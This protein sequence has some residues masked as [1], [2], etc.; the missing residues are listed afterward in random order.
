MRPRLSLRAAAL[1]VSLLAA[2]GLPDS[3]AALPRSGESWIQLRTPHFTFF[4]NGSE[5]ATRNI[6]LDLE[7]LRSSLS[8]LN[9][10]LALA[11][12][13]PTS[14]YVFK[15]TSSFAPYRL[16]YEGRLQSGEGYFVSHPYGNHVAINA[17][18]RGDAT[19]VIYHE[20]LHDVLNHNYPGLPLWLNEGLAEF[21][22]TFE[23]VGGEAK[24]GLPI[25]RHVF[26]LRDN[27]MIPLR[28]LLA[29][30]T[31]SR[32]YNEGSRRGVF[33]AQSWALVH[34]LLTG[35][36]ERR[37]Q[38]GKYLQAMLDGAGSAEAFERSF[39]DLAL[40]ERDL[41]S[42]VR[43]AAFNYL[44]VPVAEEASVKVEVAPLAGAD[45]L[46]RLGDLLLH[47]GD[48]KHTA[49]EEHFRAALAAA[50]GHGP[51]TAG[52]GRIAASASRVAEARAHYARAAQLAPDDYFIHYLL[53]V[54]LLEPAPEPG[55][56]PQARAA[57]QKSVE[58]RP[59]FAEGWGRWAQALSYEN[60]LPPDSVMVFE[61]AYH[62]M[63]AREDFAFN[64]ALVY[65][66]TGQRDKAEK[67]IDQALVPRNRPEIVKQARQAV[68]LG[69]W[70]EI[71]KTLVEPGK[72]AEALPRLEALLPR[73]EDPQRGLTLRKRLDEI[74]D[75]ADY[76]SFSERYNRA[77]D[78][79][80][81]GKDADALKLLEDLA[82]NTRNA[83][84]AEEARSLLDR[85][86]K[87]P[88]RK[89]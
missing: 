88:K 89:P 6:A 40:L 41:R 67:L 63:P 58:L 66:R 3:A 84:Q 8:Q 80:N 16:V 70:E 17:D 73:L 86:K 54:S 36:P 12:P 9:P 45:T 28:E 65:A 43:S 48:E 19:R 82:A 71:E 10:G 39:G 78:L 24:V 68:L 31:S 59:D 2:S 23:V 32:D 27:A 33:Y 29:M 53:G 18:P 37:R 38:T 83:G 14:I 51:A 72:L 55:A 11:S 56:L 30:N 22:S 61:T 49:A 15:G 57:L 76:N 26:W 87:A 75:V 13:V 52:L 46:Y 47:N 7:R 64:L 34:H 42:Y 79:L 4:S 1:A 85:A 69:E 21:Y 50:P 35:S 74:R 62:L 20:Y 25:S 60:P 5:R 81:A 44:R 77:V